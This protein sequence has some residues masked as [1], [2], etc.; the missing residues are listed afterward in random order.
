MNDKNEKIIEY[1]AGGLSEGLT[2][3][4]IAKKH[5]VDISVINKQLKMG[6]KVE[7]EHSDDDKI[8]AEISKD[9]LTETPFYYDYLEAMEKSF[10]KNY[11][12]DI[13]RGG[14]EDEEAEEEKGR[15]GTEDDAISF[16]KKNPN[17]SDDT[18]HEWCEKQG[19]KVPTLEGQMYKLATKYVQS[20]K[21]DDKDSLSSK[22][23]VLKRL[24][25]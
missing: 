13:E 18:L 4:D 23:S 25:G 6:L 24:F 2:A 17:P 19:I 16:L 9:H 8:A 12:E 5:S 1:I 11:E 14:M 10:K 15:K 22:D 3:E 21:S 7:H 20:M